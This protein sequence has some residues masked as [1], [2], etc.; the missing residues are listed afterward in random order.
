M[1]NESITKIIARPIP[2]LYHHSHHLFRFPEVGLK[3][4]QLPGQRARQHRRLDV[5]VEYGNLDR[6]QGVV[7]HGP[8][9]RLRFLH[10]DDVQHGDYRE[11]RR[12]SRQ[13]ACQPEGHPATSGFV[14]PPRRLGLDRVK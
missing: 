7:S 1:P 9:Y 5:E 13:A 3:V 4:L 2:R 14:L 6:L 11:R 8:G 12:Y 10:V